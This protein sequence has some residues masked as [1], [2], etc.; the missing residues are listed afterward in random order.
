MRDARM[1]PQPGLNKK[2]ISFLH[3]ADLHSQAWATTT[4]VAKWVSVYAY[5]TFITTGEREVNES[6]LTHLCL[7][8]CILVS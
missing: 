5:K 1:D 2:H 4:V 7:K 3:L 6:E 8:E